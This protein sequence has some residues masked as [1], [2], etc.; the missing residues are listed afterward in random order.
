MSGKFAVRRITD[1][2]MTAAIV[3]LMTSQITGQTAHEWMGII[4]FLLVIVHTVLNRV[5]YKNLLKGKYQPARVLQTIV[6][7]ALLIS[8]VLT[9]ISGILMS[10]RAVPFLRVGSAVGTARALHLGF[11]HWTFL[12]ISV[13]LGLHWGVIT[14]KA[15][16]HRALWSVLSIAGIIA[17]GY[18]LLLTIRAQIYSYMLFQVLFAFLD[19]GASPVRVILENI[20]MMASWAMISY[21]IAKIL[22]KPAKNDPHGRWISL[23]MI[24]LE[25]AAAGILSIVV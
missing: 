6:N 15:Q 20:L 13:H 9:A 23:C 17:A 24:A 11:S 18:G 7:L 16:K 8:F 12:L 1:I 3:L 22:R 5:W 2:A 14:R 25:F 19:Y 4:M 21:E 10:Q